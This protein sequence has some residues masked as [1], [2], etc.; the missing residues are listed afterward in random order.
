MIWKLK[1]YFNVTQPPIS[2]LVLKL[3]MF[4]VV[5]S[6]MPFSCEEATEAEQIDVKS[7]LLNGTW[8][9]LSEF[10][11][12]NK[13]IGI[14]LVINALLLFEPDDIVFSN[15]NTYKA[16]NKLGDETTGTWLLEKNNLTLTKGDGNKSVYNIKV[17]NENEMEWTIFY[18]KEVLGSGDNANVILTMHK[19]E[20]DYSEEEDD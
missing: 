1:N 5:F 15:D 8:F 14:K 16:K 3:F 7:V 11:T 4:V 9:R 2:S 18:S 20:Y 19:R 13:D 6:V 12:N 10:K 17:V